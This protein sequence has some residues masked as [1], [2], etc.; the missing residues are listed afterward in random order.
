MV[1]RTAMVGFLTV[2]SDS[3]VVEIVEMVAYNDHLIFISE[4]D[5]DTLLA[6]G[7]DDL[8]AAKSFGMELCFYEIVEDRDES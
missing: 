7:G 8:L 6:I 2:S 1:F 3:P 5:V 4:L